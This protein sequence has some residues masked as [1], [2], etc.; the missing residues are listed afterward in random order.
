[1]QHEHQR[2]RIESRVVYRQRLELA[3]PQLDVVDPVQPLFSRP[4]ASPLTRRPR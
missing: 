3:A 1:M 2:R 4:G